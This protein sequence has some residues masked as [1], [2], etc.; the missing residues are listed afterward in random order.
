MIPVLSFYDIV[1]ILWI[2][3]NMILVKMHFFDYNYKKRD[4]V[5]VCV[6]ME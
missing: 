5:F 1:S 6:H 4:G 3:F 2:N